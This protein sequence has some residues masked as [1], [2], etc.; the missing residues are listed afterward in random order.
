MAKK[1]NIEVEG[2]VIESLPNAR[3]RVEL[4]NKHEVLAHVSGKMS[5]HFIRVLPV[6]KVLVELYP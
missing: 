2:E 4:R 5:M 1:D 3:F 6:D